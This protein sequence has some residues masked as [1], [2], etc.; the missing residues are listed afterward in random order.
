[1]FFERRVSP[2]LKFRYAL[3]FISLTVCIIVGF[4]VFWL[5]LP[6]LM[7]V[8]MC[9]ARCV[10]T[11]FVVCNV[12]SCLYTC[13]CAL[14]CSYAVCIEFALRAA[15]VWNWSRKVQE[16]RSHI[17]IFIYT[18]FYFHKLDAV[19]TQYTFDPALKIKRKPDKQNGSTEGIKVKECVIF[20][21][22]S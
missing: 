1:M 10:C 19:N 12:C 4:V 21:C 17:F 20:C 11:N 7:V 16:S 6:T 9:G 8:Y 18:Q 14:C 13:G 3:F 15:N 2:L 5:L 22:L